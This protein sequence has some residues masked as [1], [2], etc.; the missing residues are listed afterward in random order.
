MVLIASAFWTLVL[1]HSSF[2]PLVRSASA[3]PAKVHMFLFFVPLLFLHLSLLSIALSPTPM[4]L[5]ARHVTRRE[6]LN[7]PYIEDS[8][9]KLNLPNQVQRDGSPRDLFLRKWPQ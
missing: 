5:F 2:S 7:H 9:P 1:L 4:I 3:T 8:V 6:E